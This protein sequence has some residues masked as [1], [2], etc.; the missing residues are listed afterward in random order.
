MA[1]DRFYNVARRLVRPILER[2]FHWVVRGDEHIPASGGVLL[3]ANH[4]SF[5]DGLCLAYVADR[6]GRRTKFLV[7]AS[8]FD[9]PGVGWVLRGVGDIPVG[10]R[11]DGDRSSALDAAIEALRAGWCLGVF[12]EGRISPDLEPGEPRTGVAR[13]AA[14]AGVPVLP[15]GLWGSH[16]VWTRSRWP[17][18]RRVAEAVAVGEPLYVEADDDPVAA[19]DRIMTAICAQVGE[20]RRLYP[21]RPPAGQEAWWYRSPDTAR[22]RPCQE[23]SF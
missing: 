4:I 6:R 13:M 12:P 9:V 3:A 22:L 8:V 19:A 21:E 11:R 10:V 7:K 18:P 14:A 23:D 17:R 2:G 16:R 20:A 1:D 15:V 5:L